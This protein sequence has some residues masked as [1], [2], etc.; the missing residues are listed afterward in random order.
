MFRRIIDSPRTYFILA[1]LFFV[2]GVL[3]TVRISPPPRDAGSIQDLE[4]LAARD[5]LNVVF[6]LIDTL[7][8]DHL[9]AYGYERETSPV[10]DEI[11][12]Y[13]VRFSQTTAQSSWTKASMASL[14]TGK[15]PAMSGVLRYGHGLGAEAEMPAELLKEAGFV[16]AGLYR[17]GWVD[18]NFGFDQ[19]FDVYIHPRMN[20]NRMEFQRRQLGAQ[21]GGT[22]L[23]ITQAAIEFMRQYRHRRFMLYLHYMDV[24]QYAYDQNSALFGTQYKDYYDNAI[25]WTD[26][27]LGMVLQELIDQDLFDKTILVIASDHGEEF[28]DHGREG[29]AKTLYREVVDTPLIFSLPFRLEEGLVIDTLVQNVDIWPTILDLLGIE[30]PAGVTGR[31]LVPLM[32]GEQ[33]GFKGRAMF[34]QLDG[35]WGQEDTEPAPFVAVTTEDW[36]MIRHLTTDRRELFDR[37]ADPRERT[38]V[39]QREPEVVRVLDAQI[40]EHL[41]AVEE[42]GLQPVEFEMDE[43]R[44]NQL[45]ALGYNVGGKDN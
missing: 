38:N 10:I 32:L 45:R 31:S 42:K 21:V 3:V 8:A 43:L 9:S 37:I 29:H 33:D 4:G 22:D 2:I 20:E 39:A 28:R 17:N 36:K 15:H 30:T 34:S 11:A 35:T 13:G 44:L 12:R 6:V 23:D 24:H 26:S 18:A 41:A 27:N 14:W 19:G 40:D 16:T 1:A 25:R 5:D 7:R